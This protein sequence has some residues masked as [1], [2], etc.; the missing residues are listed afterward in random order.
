MLLRKLPVLLVGVI[1][2]MAMAVPAL[3]APDPDK[4]FGTNCGTSAD[5]RA[6][7]SGKGNFGQCHKTDDF[8]G[9]KPV[10]GNESSK[11]NPS[12]VSSGEADCRTVSGRSGSRSVTTVVTDCPPG[13]EPLAEAQIDFD[14]ERSSGKALCVRK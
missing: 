5:H 14:P 1:V 6:N 10:E 2:L 4:C 12:S 9:E 8:S 3:G 13:K 11:L 7:Q